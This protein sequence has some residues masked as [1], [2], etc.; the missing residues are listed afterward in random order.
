MNIENATNEAKN[1]VENMG[2]NLKKMADDTADEMR[3][4]G[5]DW[6]N[7]IQ[8]HPMQSVVFGII[9]Y[10]ALKG[11]LNKKNDLCK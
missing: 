7:Y 5:K 11:V 8:T 1:K 2:E 4:S 10:Y 9:G 6:V 3:E